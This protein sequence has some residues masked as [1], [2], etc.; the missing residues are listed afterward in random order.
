MRI[1]AVPAIKAVCRLI[2]HQKLMHVKI[3]VIN[4]L[5]IN[6]AISITGAFR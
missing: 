2:F 5:V 4:R 6:P 3:S 1:V